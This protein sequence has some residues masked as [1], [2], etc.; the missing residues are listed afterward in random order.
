MEYKLRC[1]GNGYSFIVKVFG[2]ESLDFC[3]SFITMGLD[4]KMQPIINGYIKQVMQIKCLRKMQIG[5]LMSKLEKDKELTLSIGC[6]SSSMAL[7]LLNSLSEH[8]D[9]EAFAFIYQ[10]KHVV[11]CK[12]GGYS[13]L[14][15]GSVFRTRG[16]ENYRIK[17]RLFFLNQ[18]LMVNQEYAMEKFDEFCESFKP[19]MHKITA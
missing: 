14:F 1:E 19:S 13:L 18:M 9:F 6:D 12:A 10:C 8:K 3:R 4:R 5:R 7:S 16:E 11:A 15:D 17:E 2:E